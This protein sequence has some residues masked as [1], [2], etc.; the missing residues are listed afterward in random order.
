MKIQFCQSCSMPMADGL[1]GTEKDGA[2][3]PDYCKYCYVNGVFTQPDASLEDMI[4]SCVPHM[5]DEGRT[6]EEA[7]V[8]LKSTLPYLKRWKSPAEKTG[9]GAE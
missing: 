8:L 7:R 3:S 5:K 1:A 2:K 9:G 4:D 6:E